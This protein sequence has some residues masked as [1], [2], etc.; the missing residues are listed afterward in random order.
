[1]SLEQQMFTAPTMWLSLYS[2]KD[3]QSINLTC[4]QI[5]SISPS[6]DIQ[7][8][9]EHWT[10]RIVDS[11]L[12]FGAGHWE[13][14]WVGEERCCKSVSASEPL[15]MTQKLGKPEEECRVPNHSIVI[16]RRAWW[17]VDVGLVESSG[18]RTVKCPPGCPLG[19]EFT[20]R[21]VD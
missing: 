8:N 10:R 9:V 21:V 4:G 15:R 20:E 17:I 16:R 13:G 5:N 19:A 6:L 18:W 12:P 11:C 14:L 7:M 3:L 1:M 2:R